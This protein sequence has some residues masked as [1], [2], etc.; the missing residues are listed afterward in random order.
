M[1]NEPQTTNAVT[2]VS[3]TPTL[4]LDTIFDALS[5]PRRRILLTILQDHQRPLLESDLAAQIAAKEADKPSGEVTEEERQHVLTDLRHNQLPRL[6]DADMIARDRDKNTASI[7]AHPG[8]ER[9]ISGLLRSKV[10]EGEQTKDVVFRCLAN[11]RRRLV[12]SVL[13]QDSQPVTLSDLAKRVAAR[14]DETPTAGGTDAAVERIRTSLHHVH[15]PKLVEA[16]IVDY[17]IEQQLVK[18]RKLPL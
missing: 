8:L 5:N 10:S 16:G 14:T 7:V 12:V 4:T 13:D 17:D 1:S 9:G 15:L 6:A 2:Q 3:I 18:P 11:Q